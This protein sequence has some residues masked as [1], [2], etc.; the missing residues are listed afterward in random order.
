M[1]NGYTKNEMEVEVM[2]YTV[3]LILAGIIANSQIDF[4]RF[5]VWQGPDKGKPAPSYLKSS[6]KLEVKSDGFLI[7]FKF[8]SYKGKV[9]ARI[10][11]RDLNTILNQS[12]DLF[13]IFLSPDLRDDNTVY[14][15]IVNPLNTQFDMLITPNTQ[16]FEWDAN[17]QSKVKITKT[18]WEGEIFIP[19]TISPNW[20]DTAGICFIRGCHDSTGYGI[21]LI[22]GLHGEVLNSKYFTKVKINRT[23][24][25]N[26]GQLTFIPFLKISHEKD[27]NEF[28]YGGNVEIKMQNS[29]TNIVVKPDYAEIEADRYQFDLSKTGIILPEKRPFFKNVMHFISMPVPYGN[30]FY[31]RSIEQID[32]GINSYFKYRNTTFFG[33]GIRADTLSLGMIELATNTDYRNLNLS[34]TASHLFDNVGDNFLYLFPSFSYSFPDKGVSLKGGLQYSYNFKSRESIHNATT[35]MIYEHGQNKFNIYFENAH[36]GNFS[37]TCGALYFKNVNL[38]NFLLN[39]SHQFEHKLVNYISLQTFT[40]RIFDSN[41]EIRNYKSFDAGLGLLSLIKLSF[42]HVK[43]RR[44]WNGILFQ[45]ETSGGGIRIDLPASNSGMEVKYSFGDLWGRKTNISRFNFYT[46][47]KRVLNVELSAFLY[48]F[49]DEFKPLLI[50]TPFSDS[51]WF[52]F[53]LRMSYRFREVNFV[54]VFFERETFENTNTV[55]IMFEREF[56]D[57]NSIFYVVMNSKYGSTSKYFNLPSKKDFKWAVKLSYAIKI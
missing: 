32:Y 17:W 34:L 47:I 21:A 14:G 25:G 29:N 9:A 16:T 18:G 52:Q 53:D 31:S 43:E 3:F 49:R 1:A 19:F 11:T 22:A 56:P 13:I 5:V 2:G 28:S 12:D 4:N 15:L 7:R 55:N 40:E 38:T 39:G 33:T 54:R 57:V 10:T 6:V 23:A 50:F 30:L 48:A 45:N 44:L 8:K 42:S 41:D 24:S 27:N 51:C 35:G 20:G 37:P 46:A 26:Y 36:I